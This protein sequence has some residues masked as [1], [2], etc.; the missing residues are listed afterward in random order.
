MK[1]RRFPSGKASFCCLSQPTAASVGW[2]S[3]ENQKVLVDILA[4]LELA[5]KQMDRDG[6]AAHYLFSSTQLNTSFKARKSL[7]GDAPQ[8]CALNSAFS[9][10]SL[11]G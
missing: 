2:G 4:Y 6:V 10:A 8:S 7:I 5:E 11:L 1:K 3:R 9:H